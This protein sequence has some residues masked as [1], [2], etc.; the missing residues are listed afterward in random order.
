MDDGGPD[1][2]NLSPPSNNRLNFNDDHLRNEEEKLFTLPLDSPAG[3]PPQSIRITPR[4][5][6][7]RVTNNGLII[8]EEV[9]DVEEEK[10]EKLQTPLVLP[11]LLHCVDQLSPQ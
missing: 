5:M 10:E 6:S 8:E 9:F 7:S 2:S 4:R 11:T 1:E 3:L